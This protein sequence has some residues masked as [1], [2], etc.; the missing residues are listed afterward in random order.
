MTVQANQTAK[1]R[2]LVLHTPDAPELKVLERLPSECTIVGIGRTFEDL[3][4]KFGFLRLSSQGH[5]TEI[6]TLINRCTCMLPAGL[7][8]S[9][10]KSVN[11]LLNCGA[12]VKRNLQVLWPHLPNLEWLHSTAAGVEHILFP[13]LV[14]GPVTL[15]NAKVRA[16]A[17]DID[18][19]LGHN[20]Y[21]C[22]HD[23]Q[24]PEELKNVPSFSA[25]CKQS[26]R[27]MY[28]KCWG[29][30]GQFQ[31]FLSRVHAGS[32]QLVCQ[33]LP[34]AQSPAEGQAVEALRCGGAEVIATD[35]FCAI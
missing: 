17:L 32:L 10:W 16:H 12:P 8:D 21:V 5:K 7:T 11:V 9:D 26:A 3:S 2:I 27:V 22:T 15:T 25:L 20:A 31:P 33:G 35:I 18:S 14:E 30:A 1:A 6:R 24:W 19:M 13:D 23:T 4:G 28:E 34:S 29:R